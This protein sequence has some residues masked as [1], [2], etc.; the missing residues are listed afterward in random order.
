MKYSSDV[1]AAEAMKVAYDKIRSE[2]GNVIIGQDEVV[3]RLLTAI[4]CQGHCLL[5]GVPGLAK[6]LLIQTIA[7]SLD[8]NFNRIQFTPD[9]MPSD[10][11][12][13]ETLDQNR[14]FKFIKGP[15]FANIILAD[16]INRTPPKTQSALLEAMQE[17]SV[18]IAGAK[19]SLDRPFFVLATQNPIEQEGTYPLPEAQLDRFMF[20]IQLDYPSYTEEV[21]IVKNTTTDSRYQ[22]QKV[23]SA[24]EITDFQHLVRR[25]P[26]TDHVIEYAVKLVHKTRPNGSLAIKD[27]ND[28]LEWGAGPRASQ[29]LIL[30][31]KC[32]ALLSGKYSPDIEDVKAVA[33]P[34]LRH[35]I[36]RNFKAEAEG[37]SVD[38]II[39]RLL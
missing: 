7:S 4:F 39:G 12:G 17:Y 35:R 27:T 3:K 36:I 18:T 31:A 20:M 14:N 6:T 11:L 22:V 9:L 26:V 34:V 28:Y 33:L 5:V 16:E 2:I 21:S 25:V 32:N 15:I 38:D 29:A 8:L 30:A 1:E 24:Q 10:I 23:I 13:S 37:I 19:H